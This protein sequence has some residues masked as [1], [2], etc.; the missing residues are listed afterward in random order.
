MISINIFIKTS[1]IKTPLQQSL[2]V[3]ILAVIFN[4]IAFHGS[5]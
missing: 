4:L 3:I 5:F 2:L 1:V